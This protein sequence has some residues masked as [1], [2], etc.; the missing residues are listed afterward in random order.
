ME[1]EKRNTCLNISFKVVDQAVQKNSA[2]RLIYNNKHTKACVSVGSE[3]LNKK[4]ISLKLKISQ[5]T[6]LIIFTRPVDKAFQ[7]YSV[8]SLWKL[9]LPPHYLPISC[10]FGKIFLRRQNRVRRRHTGFWLVV[11]VV[12]GIGESGPQLLA[13]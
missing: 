6:N 9:S 5:R 4:T 13:T 2:R 7:N 8:T 11:V 10:H 1:K 3:Y 12:R